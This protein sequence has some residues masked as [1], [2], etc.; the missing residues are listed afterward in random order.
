MSIVLDVIVLAIIGITA[1]IAAKKGFIAT[2]IELVG[3]L[4]AFYLAFTLSAAAANFTYDQFISP[5]IQETITDSVGDSVAQT[6]DEVWGSLPAIVVRGANTLGVDKEDITETISNSS[7]SSIA[8]IAQSIDNKIARPVITGFMRILIGFILF[9][10]LIIVVKILAKIINKLFSFSIIG[11][12]NK[13]LGGALG[14]V[15]GII[16]AVAAVLLLS[17]IAAVSENG[18][19]IFTNENIENSTIFGFIASFNPFY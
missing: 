5:S 19:L 17:T 13:I 7:D 15:K 18:F 3:L 14:A 10:V 11:K 4:L 1:F 8:D 16:F 6:A 12:V 9:I 2:V